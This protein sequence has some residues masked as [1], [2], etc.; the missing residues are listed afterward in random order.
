MKTRKG[1]YPIPFEW[2]VSGR[3]WLAW[4]CRQSKSYFLECDQ[5]ALIGPYSTPRDAFA[6]VEELRPA[7]SKEGDGE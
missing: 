4:K 6:W 3:R 7:P 2:I 5:G 1:F